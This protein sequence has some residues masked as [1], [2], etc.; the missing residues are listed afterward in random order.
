MRELII[1]AV[2]W[3]GPGESLGPGRQRHSDAPALPGLDTL[4]R[5][6]RM[7]PLPEGWRPFLARRLGRGDLARAA[8]A[9]VADVPPLVAS[10]PAREHYP[11]VWLATALAL[12]PGASHVILGHEGVLR[13]DPSVQ[14]RLATDFAGTFAG[15]GWQLAPL[16]SGE[17]LLYGPRLAGEVRSTEPA[18]CLGASLAPHLPHAP[19]DPALRRLTA[20]I[21]MWLHGHEI[22]MIR[23]REQLPPVSTLWLWGGGARLGTAEAV[24]AGEAGEAGGEMGSALSDD[25]FVQGLW[26]RLGAASAP[27]P[28]GLD[29]APGGGE[30][31]ARIR[32]ITAPAGRVLADFDARWV[33]PALARL[34]SGALDELH[35]IANDRMLSLRPRDRLRFWR[36]ARSV[37]EVME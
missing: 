25:A 22:N 9:A 1:I 3:Y 29:A 13:L 32:V 23:T 36:R 17:F 4:A 34:A 11:S 6:G 16:A 24:D 10:A 20:E 7:Q 31:A 33:Q 2:D 30:S 26:A 14:E 5:F 27:L 35:L 18:R 15:A 21:E 19:G 12:I 8:P 28:A 37:L